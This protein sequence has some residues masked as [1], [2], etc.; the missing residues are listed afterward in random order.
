MVDQSLRFP[1]GMV[2]DVMARIQEHYIPTDFLVLDMQGDDEIL[3]LLGRAFLYTA[4]ANNYIGSGHIHFNLPAEKVRCQFR[5][6]VN[7]EQIR[8]ERNRKR[9]QA[10]HQAAQPHYGWEDFPGKIAKYKDHI[11]EEEENTHAL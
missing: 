9:H 10:H 6:L 2:K 5:T 4:K 11:M 1:E 8:K 7:R 3:N